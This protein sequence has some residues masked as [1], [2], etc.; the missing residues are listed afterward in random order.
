MIAVPGRSKNKFLQKAAKK[1]FE[2]KAAK[3]TKG[4]EGVGF[5]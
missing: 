2:Q 4:I 1:N 5:P 3:E